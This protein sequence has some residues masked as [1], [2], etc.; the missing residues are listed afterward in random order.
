MIGRRRPQPS[1]RSSKSVS[2][3]FEVVWAPFPDSSQELALTSPADVTLLHGTRGSAKTETQLMHFRKNVGKGFGPYWRG[4][5][6]DQEYKNL[7]D[8]ITR[9]NRIFPLFNDGAQFLTSTSQLKWVWPTGEELL[10]RSAADEKAYPS[11]HGHEYPWIGI[12]EVTKYAT[13]AFLDAIMSTNR[14]SYE[15]DVNAPINQ[16]GTRIETGPIPLQVVLTTNS[17]GPGILWVKRRFILPAPNGV[18]YRTN[19]DVIDP[20]TQEEITVER[21]Q[22]A[23]FSHWSE[24]PK[25]DPKYIAWLKSI[26]DEAKKASWYNGSWDIVAGGALSHVWSAKHQIKPRFVIPEGWYLDRCMDWGS[27]EPFYIGWVAEANGEE[28]Q[29]IHPDGSIETFC[30]AP[31]SL[32]LFHEWYGTKEI[33]TNKGLKLGSDDI[34]EN[35]L[36]IER[37]LT[38]NG[39]INSKVRPGP[40]DNQIRNVNDKATDTVAKKMEDKGVYWTASDKSKGS[41]VIGLTLMADRLR[42]AKVGEGPALYFMAHCTAAI[43]TLPLLQQDEKNVEDVDTKGEDHPYD[44]IRYR[45]LAA[46]GRAVTSIETQHPTRG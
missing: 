29:I 41:R 10:L 31:G 17:Y 39:W 32:I 1:K 34:A 8:V 4:I 15:E 19:I 42:A 43:E 3:E 21:T 23:I 35:I 14:S 27:T 33:G 9:S 20:K 30:P 45:V 12:N 16:D 13:S 6:F 26:D 5:I 2:P 40:A 11:Y 18:I 44:G 36:R 37:Q 22:V 38:S 46:D 28:A 7:D 24:N 25:L